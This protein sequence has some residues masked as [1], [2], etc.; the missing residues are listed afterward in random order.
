MIAVTSSFSSPVPARSGADAGDRPLPIDA[1]LR[2]W[3]RLWKDPEL[4]RQLSVTFSRRLRVTLGRCTPATGRVVLSER[5]KSG[6]ASRLLEVL[7]HE[8]AHVAAFRRHGRGAAPHGEEWAALVR[9]AGFSPASTAVAE[10]KARKP[11][12]TRASYPFAHVCPVCHTRRYA[13]RPVSR[14]RCA[15][16]VS[17]GLDGKLMVERV[18]AG[19]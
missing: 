2:S 17:A 7:C 10:K 5:L 8:A 3:G 14:W 13:R 9:Q 11:A 16:C 6:S 1:A 4:P 12:K 19:R 15:E 18:P